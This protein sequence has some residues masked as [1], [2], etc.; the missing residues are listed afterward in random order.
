MTGPAGVWV[1]A[2]LGVA[3]IVLGGL[4]AR[5]RRRELRLERALDASSRQ[6]EHLQQAFHKFAPQEVV[7]EIVHRGVSAKGERREVT[8]LF[9]DLVGFTAMSERMDPEVLVRIL[10]GYFQAMSRAITAHRGHVS[11]FIGDGILALFGA[12]DA[13]PWQAIDAVEAALA[14]RAALARYN[15]DLARQGWPA[16][17]LG[18]GIHQGPLIAGI[19][20]SNELMEYTVIGDTVN[21]ASRIEGLTR[22]LGT[23][24]LVSAA[25]QSRLDGRFALRECEAM[26][27]KGK[28]DRIR[29][30]AVTGLRDGAGVAAAA[31]PAPA[32]ASG[33]R[34]RTTGGKARS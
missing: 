21:T 3:A 17:G 12:P 26:E 5:S 8:I 18:V 4:F 32:R 22:K 1:A 24:I 16:L 9:A 11:K 31:D 23:D 33:P 2:G 14:M 20:G 10:N 28:T 7:E 19:V 15:E 6:L 30:F 29:T 25:V 27:V 13:N 34:R